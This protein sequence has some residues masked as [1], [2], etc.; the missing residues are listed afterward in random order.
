MHVQCMC[1]A[2]IFGGVRGRMYCFFVTIV[3]AAHVTRPP[4]VHMLFSSSL[5][6]SILLALL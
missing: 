2:H 4:L 5:E 1:N 6:V 3:G